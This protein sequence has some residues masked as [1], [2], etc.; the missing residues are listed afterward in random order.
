MNT[1]RP[2]LEFALGVL[3]WSPAVFWNATM[4]E[5]IAAINGRKSAKPEKE[6]PLNRDEYEEMKRR[7]PD[8][9]C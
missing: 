9:A 3:N 1:F 2:H 6:G 7:F 5:L 4:H 8:V